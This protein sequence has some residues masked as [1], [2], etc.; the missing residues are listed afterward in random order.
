VSLEQRRERG[1]AAG[2]VDDDVAADRFRG[3]GDH[4]GNHRDLSWLD[5]QAGND[6]ASADRH[7]GLGLCG[8]ADDAL[9][10]RTPGA[11]HSVARPLAQ[12]QRDGQR[13]PCDERVVYVGYLLPQDPDGAAEEVVRLASL[14][15]AGAR[16]REDRIGLASRQAGVAFCHGYAVAAPSQ[17]QG[18]GQACEPAAGHYCV[19]CAAVHEPTVPR[20]PAARFREST[21]LVLSPGLLSCIQRPS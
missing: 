20:R 9:H 5:E 12:V 4:A 8:L 19:Q 6:R 10:Q 21:Q 2:G 17:E 14:G 11:H 1:A 15:D 7:G 3:P 18:G 13:A 16:R